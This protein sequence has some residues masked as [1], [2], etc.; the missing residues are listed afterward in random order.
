MDIWNDPND[1]SHTANAESPRANNEGPTA[2][3]VDFASPSMSSDYS[4]YSEPP[5]PVR[6][7]PLTQNQSGLISLNLLHN[8]HVSATENKIVD[9]QVRIGCE[10]DQPGVKDLKKDLAKAQVILQRLKEEKKR[11]VRTLNQEEERLKKIVGEG[12]AL[13]KKQLKEI[14]FYLGR[15]KTRRC[16]R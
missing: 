8:I 15:E 7:S 16:L 10:R 12:A 4:D 14:N 9:I 6:R 11:N 3:T 1:E 5:P 2:S 13:A